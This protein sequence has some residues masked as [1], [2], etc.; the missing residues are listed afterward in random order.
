M[1]TWGEGVIALSDILTGDQVNF[2]EVDPPLL[3]DR[4]DVLRLLGLLTLYCCGLT[5]SGFC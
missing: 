3:M 5:L 4:R 1:L 2:L